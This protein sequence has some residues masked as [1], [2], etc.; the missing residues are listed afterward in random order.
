MHCTATHYSTLQHTATHCNTMQHAAATHCNTLQHTVHHTATH[1]LHCN[2]LQHMAAHCNTCTA[3]QH[4]TAHCSTLQHNAT[5]WN[6]ATHCNT[7]LLRATNTRGTSKLFEHA[8]G[9][10]TAAR[11]PVKTDLHKW[12]E[13]CVYQKRPTY[14]QR[15][16]RKR[17]TK[18]PYT[19]VHLRVKSEST[20]EICKWALCSRT[21][22]SQETSL[23]KRDLLTQKE[24][25]EKDQ[26]KSPIHACACMSKDN[27]HT[28]K[29]T[30]NRDLN[31]LSRDRFYN[32]LRNRPVNELSVYAHIMSHK[33]YICQKRPTY[34]KR[35]LNMSKET[36]M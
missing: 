31:K 23:I 19:C 27:N 35:D 9:P 22:L 28:W 32:N 20:K 15:D 13:T 2:A 33:T 3:L 4:T 17:S 30:C 16:L 34:V 10:R 36:Y 24:N 26:Q 14:T 25:Y 6:T 18:E 29:E 11:L 12:E 7:Y 21:W 8:R 1:T 5:H